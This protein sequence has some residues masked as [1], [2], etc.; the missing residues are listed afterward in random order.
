M[1]EDK[2]DYGIEGG[3]EEIHDDIVD[4]EVLI[5]I[6]GDKLLDGVDSV[7]DV[8]GKIHAL[9]IVGIEPQD[10]LDYVLQLQALEH[11]KYVLDENNKMQTEVSKIKGVQ[12]EKME[13]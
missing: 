8:I 4:L 1:S 6:F 2:I 5:D 13:M 9:G 12:A 10:A 11:E 7:S 3:I